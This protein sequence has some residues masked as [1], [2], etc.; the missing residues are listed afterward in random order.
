MKTIALSLVAVLSLG[1]LPLA[2]PAPTPVPSA[3]SG[4]VAPMAWCDYF[5]NFPGCRRPV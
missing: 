5:P 3:G 4:T 2:T 1:A